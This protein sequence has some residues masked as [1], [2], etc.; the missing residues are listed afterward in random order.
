MS[1]PTV[2]LMLAALAGG[3][4][5]DVRRIDSV[6]KIAA[7]GGRAT[8]V[9]V[10]AETSGAV[11]PKPRE[12]DW[13][14]LDSEAALAALSKS[15]RPPNTE[16]VVRTVRGTTMVSMYF[17]DASVNWAHLVDYCYRPNGS[18]ARVAGTFNTLSARPAGEGLR[19]RRTTYFDDDGQVI[20]TKASLLELDADRPRR[21]ETFVD[22]ADPVYPALRALPFSSGLLPPPAQPD[23]DRGSVVK[24][25]RERLPAIKACYEAA[26]RRAPK[27]AG[28]VVARWSIDDAGK[29]TT[30]AWE[31][32][33]M[34]SPS[35]NACA[36]SVIEKWRFPPS[37]GQP[38]SV[39]FPFMFER[40]RGDVDLG[41][42]SQ[43]E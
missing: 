25:V 4:S 5:A 35:F 24:T 32:D 6:C 30:F 20:A 2:L 21:D 38:T 37:K 19:R 12:G 13:R 23:L 18:L 41:P 22:Q 3:G 16:A 28:K 29:V 15:D 42:L 17:Q 14:E 40:S 34:K 36:R 33:E 27:L 7:S 39:S 1:A 8:K 11:L 26:L 31:S 43:R 10:F 9:R